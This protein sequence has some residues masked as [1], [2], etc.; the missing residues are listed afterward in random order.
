MTIHPQPN[1]THGGRGQDPQR[2]FSFST[3]PFGPPDGWRNWL[4]V[5]TLTRYPDEDLSDMASVLARRHGADDATFVPAAGTTELIYRWANVC[6]EADDLV[7]VVAPTF[8]EYARAA[9]L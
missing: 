6:L 2:D 8:G 9:R 5:D 4:N 1:P 7:L 3:N